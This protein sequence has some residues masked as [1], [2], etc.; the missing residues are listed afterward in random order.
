MAAVNVV[1]S[2]GREVVRSLCRQVV[3]KERVSR[4]SI[5]EKVGGR[6][7]RCLV[8]GV[9]KECRIPRGEDGGTRTE[10][11]A[12]TECCGLRIEGAISS[13]DCVYQFG[14]RHESHL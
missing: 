1:G 9:Q 13:P 2:S 5:G 8:E 14:R 4:Q 12:G 10:R 7:D 11:T 6:E 3:R